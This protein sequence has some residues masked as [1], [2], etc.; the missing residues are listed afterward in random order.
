MEE[1]RE[2]APFIVGLILP[3]VLAILSPRAWNS[4]QRF[5]TTYGAALVIGT[6]IA[7]F[8]RE[9]SHG[10]PEAIISIVIDSSLVFAASQ[11]AYR[12]FWKQI[13]E[14]YLTQSRT[15]STRR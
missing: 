14:T 9:L 3:P 11:V 1:L 4:L 15:A 10:I 7:F 2:M 6:V 12:L 13:L 8:M 5:W